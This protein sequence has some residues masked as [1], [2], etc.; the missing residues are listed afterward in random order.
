[1][2]LLHIIFISLCAV[3]DNSTEI[4]RRSDELEFDKAKRKRKFTGDATHVQNG[5]GIGTKD[6][7]VRLSPIVVIT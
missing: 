6:Q 7:R 1:M 4:K 2:S 5:L 3:A